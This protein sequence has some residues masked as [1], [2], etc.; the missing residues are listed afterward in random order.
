[1]GKFLNLLPRSTHQN[2]LELKEMPLPSNPPDD[3]KNGMV[4]TNMEEKEKDCKKGSNVT[5]WCLDKIEKLAIPAKVATKCQYLG[6]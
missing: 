5:E 3:N 1:M 6:Q 4:N 2:V